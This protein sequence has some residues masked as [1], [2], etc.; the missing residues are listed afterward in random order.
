MGEAGNGRAGIEMALDLKPDVMVMD[1]VMPELDGV[2]A[3]L[4]LLKDWP[5]GK[6]LSDDLLS[7]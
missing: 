6:N 3:T 5:R 1:L 7:R 2:E 4:K